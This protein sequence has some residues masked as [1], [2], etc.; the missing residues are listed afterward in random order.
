MFVVSVDELRSGG[1]GSS[2]PV[3]FFIVFIMCSMLLHDK[4]HICHLSCF[5]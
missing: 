5:V 2:L 3:S 4:L 1:S